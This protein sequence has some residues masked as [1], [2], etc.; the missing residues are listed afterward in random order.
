MNTITFIIFEKIFNVFTLS[1]SAALRALS[2]KR[3]QAQFKHW[4]YVLN[5]E[6]ICMKSG[7]TLH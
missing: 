6:L 3:L 4:A 5:S 2:W 1:F 7:T